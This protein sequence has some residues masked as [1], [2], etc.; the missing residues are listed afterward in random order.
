MPPDLQ[1][2]AILR[3]YILDEVTK[4]FGFSDDGLPRSLLGGVF[5]S[6]AHRFARM[7]IEFDQGIARQGLQ[8]ASGELLS[9]FVEAV[10]VQN[11]ANVPADGPLLVACNHPGAFDSVVVAANLARADLKVVVSGVPFL[12][13][14]P[15]LKPHLIYA[16]ADVH[17][18][19]TA[20][21]QMIRHM[22]E[23]GAVL[24]FASGRVDPDPAVLPGAYQALQHWSPSI[25]I[26]LR[27]APE[28]QLLPTMI[29]GVLSPA[30]LKLPFIRLQ[31]E[32]WKQ[33]RLAEYFQVAGQLYFPRRFRF[34]P[35]LT[36]G[37][38]LTLSD[39]RA[40][41]SASGVMA[42][43]AEQARHVLDRHLESGHRSAATLG[44]PSR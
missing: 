26:V 13:S 28:T 18:R 44:S 11:I 21:R 22:R 23:G 2:V 20:V 6:P 7:A 34:N 41:S 33:R 42:A 31:K 40:N 3:N 36:F 30:A 38:P 12:H 9:H 29:S 27:R 16:P 32:A 1:N 24:I 37:T 14:L 39:L 4:A 5:R 35:R 17:D 43:I 15:A 10:Q 19:M 8:L 25:E